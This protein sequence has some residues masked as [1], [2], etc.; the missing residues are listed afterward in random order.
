MNIANKRLVREIKKSVDW[1]GKNP[2]SVL[3]IVRKPV[4]YA[5]LRVSR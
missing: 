2:V 4:S 1:F 5:D 3:Q